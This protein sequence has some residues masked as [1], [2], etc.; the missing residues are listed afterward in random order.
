MAALAKKK[1]HELAA[2][3]KEIADFVA[4]SYKASLGATVLLQ[5]QDDSEFMGRIGETAEQLQAVDAHQF[6][7]L[8]R[9]TDLINVSLDPNFV[10]HID[11][12]GRVEDDGLVAAPQPYN[13]FESASDIVI[14]IPSRER[15]SYD[16]GEEA[17]LQIQDSEHPRDA[18][19]TIPS[20]RFQRWS[21]KLVVTNDYRTVSKHIPGKK[22][23]MFCTLP[24]TNSFSVR[25]DDLPA[26]GNNW[27]VG[28]ADPAFPLDGWER[29][30]PCA[31]MAAYDGVPY[32]SGGVAKLPIR[33]SSIQAPFSLQKGSIVHSF[34]DE[35]KH[36]VSF[37][38]NDEEPQVLLSNV[39]GELYPF[40]RIHSVGVVLTL[41]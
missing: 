32:S 25:V 1:K 19:A 15:P 18:P 13:S 36:T 30:I 7:M 12:L 2:Q 3:A 28:W 33:H 24:L 31:I 27:V 14:A 41:T 11:S 9:M 29:G 17:F 35:E 40:L 10:R 6:M 16:E 8:P 38:V 22:S 23:N 34:Y 39:T 21:D 5:K 37:A 26:A 4:A 20:I